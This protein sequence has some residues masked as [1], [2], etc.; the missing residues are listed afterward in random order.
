MPLQF[1]MSFN[2]S[3]KVKKRSL[4]NDIS[5]EHKVEIKEAFDLFDADKDGCLDYHE[6]KVRAFLAF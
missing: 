4:K 3:S 6:L 5:D 1:A 2:G